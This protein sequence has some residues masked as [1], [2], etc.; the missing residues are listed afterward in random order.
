MYVII[1]KECDVGLNRNFNIDG[2]N[3]MNFVQGVR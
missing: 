3:G 1:N 2:E